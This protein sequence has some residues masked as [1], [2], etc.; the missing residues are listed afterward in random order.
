MLKMLYTVSMSMKNTDSPLD[1]L[2]FVEIVAHFSR[3]D[4][5]REYL[6]SLRWPEGAVCPHCEN[7]DQEKI[8]KIEANKE[9]KIR[10]GLY[11]CA[12]C[13]KQFT[14]TVGTIFE[15]SHIPLGKWLIAWHMLCC[16]K[17]GVSALQM[18][19]MLGLGSYR[20]AHFMMHRIR[21]ALKDES[22]SR[23][24]GGTVEVDQTKVGGYESRKYY[25][26][27]G[28]TGFSN[29]S[30]VTTFVERYG[31]KRSM[32][33]KDT[34]LH[35]AVHE[36]VAPNSAIVSDQTRQLRHIGKRQYRLY[37]VKHSDGQYVRRENAKFS[38][39][40]NSVESSFALLKRGVV[41]TFHQ[42]SKKHLPLYLAEFDFRWNKRKVS[43]GERTVSAL[44][45]ASGKRL[46][47]K[48]LKG[49]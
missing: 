24:L 34:S 10:P 31:D 35:Q 23:P 29:K 16:S 18:Q 37:T 26:D 3:E 13:K 12:A 32:V 14:V 5:A 47:Y 36:N 6:E 19:R 21:Y 43:D 49:E 20:T 7:N 4:T 9:K 1:D 48:R 22:F 40:V 44:K 27:E 46:T 15:D 17:K 30:T 2:S 11:Q 39:H 41:G 45:R 38:V 42:I 28:K 8:W 25:T 33:L